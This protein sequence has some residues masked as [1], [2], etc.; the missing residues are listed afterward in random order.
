MFFT[1]SLLHSHVHSGFSFFCL[2][3]G[4]VHS[5][6]TLSSSDYTVWANSK[7]LV[8]RKNHEGPKVTELAPTLSRV[9]T[10]GPWTRNRGAAVRSA[11]L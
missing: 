2:P 6:R 3:K 9:Q 5:S 1:N 4:D 11:F 10:P 8:C 7:H